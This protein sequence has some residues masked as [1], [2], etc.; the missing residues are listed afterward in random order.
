MIQQKIYFTDATYNRMYEDGYL[1]NANIIFEKALCRGEIF[2]IGKTKSFY[3]VDEDLKQRINKAIETINLMIYKGYT[4]SNKETARSY[5]ATGENSEF[6]VR[7]KE[8][9]DI[10][11]GSD[12]E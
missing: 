12:K 2:D 3:I 11:K 10:L 1:G 6:G 9:L 4:I 8:L 7:A 5:M